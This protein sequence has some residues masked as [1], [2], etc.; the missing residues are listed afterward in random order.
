MTAWSEAK[1]RLSIL[2]GDRGAVYTEN[3]THQC[4]LLFWFHINIPELAP[5]YSNVF[6][7][8]ALSI[9]LH[10]YRSYGLAG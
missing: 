9:R 6:N 4:S 2:F 3:W 8:A 1:P 7:M 10:C 5:Y